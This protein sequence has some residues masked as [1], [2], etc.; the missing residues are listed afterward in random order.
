MYDVSNRARLNSFA[1]ADAAA[2]LEEM[3][4]GSSLRWDVN[5]SC[6]CIDWAFKVC[7]GMAMFCWD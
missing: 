3:V 1:E 4:A 7:H 6:V 2:R 5:K